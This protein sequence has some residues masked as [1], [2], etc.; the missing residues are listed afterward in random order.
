MSIPGKEAEVSLREV[1]KDT[2]REICGLSVA[3]TQNGFVAENA[4][5]I[6]Q[7]YFEPKAWFRAI[8]A[9]ETAVGFV[10]LYDDAETPE[11]YLWRLM[12]DGRFQGNGYGRRAIQ[13]LIDYLHTR[14]NANA[15]LTSYV[16][17]EGSPQGFYSKLGFTETGVVH[18]IEKEMRLDLN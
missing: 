1:T 10:M 18:G 6:A 13:L 8:Y 17:G 7:A 3:E 2:V 5:S 15:L 4:V 16:P 14:P 11:Y 12:V 9:D